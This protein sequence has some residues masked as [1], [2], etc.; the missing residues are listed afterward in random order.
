MESI[1]QQVEEMDKLKIDK[2][3]NYR[4]RKLFKC[5]LGLNKLESD[6]FA[7]LLKN[8]D[9]GTSELKKVLEMDRSSVQRALQS[10]LELNLIVRD[11][12][13]LKDYSEEINLD[14]PIKRGYLYVYNTKELDF[15]K[16][17]LKILLSKWYKSMISY[18]NDLES[19]FDCYE[20]KGELC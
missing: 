3:G 20:I 15:I 18:V 1:N 10:L 8:K 11:Q 4:S 19:L 5:I 9:A 17:Q 16:D 13:S 2:K 7:Y 14:N 12:M 6:V